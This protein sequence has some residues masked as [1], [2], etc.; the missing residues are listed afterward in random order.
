MITIAKARKILGQLAQNL[1]D[2][3]LQKEIELNKLLVEV[4]LTQ[5][6]SSKEK[7]AYFIEFFL[8]K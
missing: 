3:E 7:N 5:Y 8:T 6:K 4:V 1:T 2:E